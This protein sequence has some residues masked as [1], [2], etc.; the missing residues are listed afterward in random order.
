MNYS[1]IYNKI[2][3]RG[4]NRTLL[5]Y[6]ENHHIIPRCLGGNDDKANLVKLTAEEH[7]VCHQLL[8]KIYPG[9]IGLLASVIKMSGYNQTGRKCNNKLFGWI[10]RRMQVLR[11]GVPLSEETKAKI[12]AARQGQPPSHTTPHSDVSKKKISESRA[13]KGTAAKSEETKD[14]MSAAAIGRKKS[15]EH[16]ESISLSKK[17]K[18]WTQA[19]I[20]AQLNKRKP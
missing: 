20:D 7:Y 16:K 3:S 8:V 17:G 2:I 10:K 15:Q 12:S 18:P 1:L 6:T 14:R 11:A 9:H 4:Q 19:R 5:G 13:G